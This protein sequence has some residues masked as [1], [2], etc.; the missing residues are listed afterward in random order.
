MPRRAEQ[1][2]EGGSDRK[3][4]AGIGCQGIMIT[5]KHFWFNKYRFY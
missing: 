2:R 1:I 3:T 5:S 4:N